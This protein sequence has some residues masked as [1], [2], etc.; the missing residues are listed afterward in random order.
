MYS[1]RLLHFLD[2]FPVKIQIE[3]EQQGTSF[4]Y[5]NMNTS[6]VNLNFNQWN[7]DDKNNEWFTITS[8]IDFSFS[9][10]KRKSLVSFFF[11][12]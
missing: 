2:L 3:N 10:E 11:L 12:I 7:E 1:D 8:G 5:E 4:K 9:I 6:L